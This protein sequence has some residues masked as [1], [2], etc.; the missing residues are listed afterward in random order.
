MT[1]KK[2][3]KQ[4]ATDKSDE[5]ALTIY[6]LLDELSPN[7]AIGLLENLKLALFLAA[8]ITIPEEKK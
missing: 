1:E 7:E 5:L 4:N 2:K 3:S 8:S 6:D